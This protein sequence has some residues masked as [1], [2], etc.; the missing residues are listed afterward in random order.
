MHHFHM[1]NVFLSFFPFSLFFWA[2][3]VSNIHYSFFFLVESNIHYSNCILIGF[4]FSTLFL[5]CYASVFHYS[6][7]RTSCTISAVTFLLFMI[8]CDQYWQYEV[9]TFSTV[10][11]MNSI[12]LV[13][14]VFHGCS[15]SCMFFF[16]YFIVQPTSL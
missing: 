4:L 16:F 3:P 6:K 12:Y 10:T 11:I 8:D 2:T 1:Y 9:T 14:I 5:L 13:P 7:V 15:Y